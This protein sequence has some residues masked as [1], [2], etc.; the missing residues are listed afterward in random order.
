[1]IVSKVTGLSRP[2]SVLTFFIFALVISIVSWNSVTPASATTFQFVT[3]KLMARNV[4]T[5]SAQTSGIDG[6]STYVGI[7]HGGWVNGSARSATFN[8]YNALIDQATGGMNAWTSWTSQ[9][10]LGRNS[11]WWTFPR[12]WPIDYPVSGKITY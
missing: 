7:G 5:F 8:Q 6:G 3:G 2:A 9:T 11:V 10:S 4:H 12:S 1:M